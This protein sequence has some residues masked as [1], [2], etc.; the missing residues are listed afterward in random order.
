VLFAAL[1]L[2]LLG[3]IKF[4]HDDE[5]PKNDF[6]VPFLTVTRFSFAIV[7]LIFSVYMIP[8]LWGAPLKGNICFCTAYGYAG[9]Q[10]FIK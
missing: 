3:K 8:G 9:F 6:G 1:G 7:A 2:Y 10:C 4:S 5:L